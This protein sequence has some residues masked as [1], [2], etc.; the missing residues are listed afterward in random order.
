VVV[1]AAALAGSAPPGASAQQVTRCDQESHTYSKVSSPARYGFQP[2]K[3]VELASGRDGATIQ[4]GLVR[5]KVP[6]GERVPVIVDAGPY[7]HPMQTLDLRRCAP[8]LTENFVPHGYA[9]ALVAVRGTADSGG[10]MD[11]FGPGERADLNQAITWLARQPWSTGAVGMTGLSYDGS[12]PWEVASFGNPHLKTIVPVEGVPDIFQLLFGGGTPDWRGPAVLNDIY[13]VQSIVSYLAG[14]DPQHTVEVT[15][16]PDYAVA[17]AAS[18]HSAQSGEPDPFGYWAARRFRDR[19][20]RNY[21]GSVLLVQGLQD[22]NVNPG[23]QYPWIENLERRGLYVK[24][25][26][27][28]WG[29]TN[30]D[31]A[32]PPDQR[33]DYA[34]LLLDWFDRW[35][36]GRSVDLGPRVQVEDSDGRW[37]NAAEWPPEEPATTLWLTA[38]QGLGGEPHRATGSRLLAP[39]PAHTQAGGLGVEVPDSLGTLC[40]PPNCAYFATEPFPEGYRF[41]GLPRLRVTVTPSGPA[42]QLSAYLYEVTAAGATRL[43]WGQVD[44]RFPR[45][46]GDARRVEPGKPTTVDFDLQPLDAVVAPNARLALVLSEGTAYNRLASLP[47]FPMRLEVGGT[48][49]SLTLSRVRPSAADFFTP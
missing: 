27:G 45:G 5:P 10:C 39:D 48:S 21:R 37:R 13:Y 2:Q 33:P 28:Q 38:D 26:I 15:A 35:L 42:G 17:N 4:I 24:H 41:A 1:L 25:L 6:P 49:G 7:Y 3:V 43:G 14:R 12:T 8:R 47:N 46:D 36:K 22:W 30:P 34:D 32:D 31:T 20:E 23:L 9:V 40:G 19:V 44:L 16:C 29:H 11:L 18:V